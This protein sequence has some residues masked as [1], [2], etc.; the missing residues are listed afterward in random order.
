M[1]PPRIVGGLHER[2]EHPIAERGR[3]EVADDQLDPERPGARDQHVDCLC[4]TGVGH[5]E[6]RRTRHTFDPSG[7]D[8]MEHRH[9]FGSRGRFVQKRSVGDLH[10]RQ[11]ADHRLEREERFEAALG[12]FRLIRRVGRIPPG[13]FEYVAH[14]DARCQAVVIAE[15]EKG[16]E[17]LVA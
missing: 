3:S 15:A 13:I 7:L 12:D 16:T 2:A 6:L 4:E 9:R 1:H 14:D 5:E 11:I 8:A 10:P 17:D